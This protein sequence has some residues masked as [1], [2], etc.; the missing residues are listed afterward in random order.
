MG[1]IHN[2]LI[3][4]TTG[5]DAET[6]AFR[7]LVGFSILFFGK[8]CIFCQ[9]SYLE[10]SSTRVSCQNIDQCCLPLINTALHLRRL[11]PI[12]ISSYFIGLCHNL[13]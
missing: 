4:T 6:W 5:L 11:V 7:S 1:E 13:A 10:D 9:N 12:R 8:R 3:L 2:S